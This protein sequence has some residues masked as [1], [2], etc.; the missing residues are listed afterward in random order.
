MQ[1]PLIIGHRG[2]SAYAPENTMAAFRLAMKE[3]ADGIEFDVRLSRDQ[4]PVVIHDDNLK[5]TGLDPHRVSDLTA[6]ELKEIEVGKWFDPISCLNEQIPT[7]IELLDFFASRTGLLYL[8]MKSSGTER[9]KLAEV[10][11]ALLN[12][13]TVKDRVIVE[14]FELSTIQLLKQLH[15]TIKT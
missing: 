5:R 9:E 4:I 10:C 15:H 13:S 2:A 6:L 8:E 14:C 1:S 7:L 11:C 12:N 3:G